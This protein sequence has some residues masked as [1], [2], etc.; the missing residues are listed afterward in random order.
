MLLFTSISGWS[1]GVF[2]EMP[3]VLDLV[4]EATPLEAL[5][6]APKKNASAP[7]ARQATA[8]TRANIMFSVG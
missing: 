1:V 3:D 6:G 4:E 7:N 8:T 2:I 5:T